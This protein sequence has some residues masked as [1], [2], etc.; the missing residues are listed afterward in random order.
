MPTVMRSPF[1]NGATVAA[2]AAVTQNR[3]ASSVVRSG[4]Y[5]RRFP[6]MLLPR[7][8]PVEFIASLPGHYL[9]PAL[10][11][12]RRGLGCGWYRCL[13]IGVPPDVGRAHLGAA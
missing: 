2:Q 9:L 7:V 1:L 8:E 13:R 6:V 12:D 11:N 5:V 4:R 3:L 10:Q